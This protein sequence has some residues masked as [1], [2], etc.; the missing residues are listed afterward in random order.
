MDLR[1]KVKRLFRMCGHAM[2]VTIHER[3][4]VLFR[5]IQERTGVLEREMQQRKT[6]YANIA[7]NQTALLQ[8]AAHQTA[9]LHEIAGRTTVKTGGTGSRSPEASLMEFLYSYLPV[10]GAI[11]IGAHTGEISESLLANG[12]EV[13]AFEPFPPSYEKL[14]GRLG[15]R[16]N[17]HPFRLAI[18]SQDAEMPLHLA[19]QVDGQDR[20]DPTLFH[21]LAAPA[22]GDG[23]RFNATLPVTVT[24]LASLHASQ[25]IP[26]QVGLVK[27]DTGG[28]DL[29][30]I[31]GMGVHRYPVVVAGFRDEGIPFAK[32]GHSCALQSLVAEMRDRGYLWHAVLYEI[33]MENQRGYYSNYSRTIANSFGNVFFFQDFEVFSQADAW[34]AAALPRAYFTPHYE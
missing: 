22:T 25:Q 8:A 33:W 20:D 7:R 24:S 27:M 18:G 14:V 1:G 5:V 19:Q 13:Y 15:N 30:V 9:I 26:E 17:F 3:L 12:Y 6:E 21:S 16:R 23:L 4:D 2:V 11:D 32:S 28:F 31:R 29:E 34:C 10:R